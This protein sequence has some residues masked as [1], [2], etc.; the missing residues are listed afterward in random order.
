MAAVSSP[1]EAAT[2]REVVMAMVVAMAMDSKIGTRSQAPRTIATMGG[3]EARTPARAEDTPPA[4][5]STKTNCSHRESLA[6]KSTITMVFR[7]KTIEHRLKQGLP[8]FLSFLLRLL[9]VTSSATTCNIIL[10]LIYRP[11]PLLPL[12]LWLPW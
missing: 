6:A 10:K 2:D 5:A 4:R 9:R 1:L 7:E 3:T 8:A 11:Q 12:L